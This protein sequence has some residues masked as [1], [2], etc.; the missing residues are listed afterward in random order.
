MSATTLRR[1][2]QQLKSSTDKERKEAAATKTKLQEQIKNLE[3]SVAK[4]RTEVEESE[5]AIVQ[6]RKDAL[7]ELTQSA[8]HSKKFLEAKLKRQE[9]RFD[10]ELNKALQEQHETFQAKRKKF[11]AV[12]EKLALQA[13]EL[14]EEVTALKRAKVDLEYKMK[15][16]RSKLTV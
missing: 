3:E 1:D 12:N 14:S 5:A 16:K 15:S 11:S 6:V 10:E 13:S 9:M 7:E 8:A 4:Y 2:L